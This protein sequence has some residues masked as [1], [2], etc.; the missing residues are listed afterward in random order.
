MTIDYD[1]EVDA[2]FINISE[3]IPARTT[4]V[5]DVCILDYDDAGNLVR[6]ELLSVFGFAGA[7]LH[8]LAAKGIISTQ[9]AEEA[10]RELRI[11]LVAA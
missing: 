10:L 3:A 11:E 8:D 4:E 2:A 5:S 6:I 9:L 1:P 7:S